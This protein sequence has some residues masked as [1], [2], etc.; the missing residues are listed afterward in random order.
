MSFNFGIEIQKKKYTK[1]A[2]NRVRKAKERHLKGTSIEFFPKN[3]ND[4][5]KRLEKEDLK[6][7]S[8]ISKTLQ[9][10]KDTDNSI[11]C[12]ILP[13]PIKGLFYWERE[14]ADDI[15][16]YS[17][18]NLVEQA[19]EV[20]DLYGEYGLRQ[21]FKSCGYWMILEWD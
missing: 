6:I 12:Y 2:F 13:M 10:I 14:E 17:G 11:R 4:S 16:E 1:E 21:F 8:V 3:V 18:I 19:F 15:V 7:R 5:M 20:Y 9:Q